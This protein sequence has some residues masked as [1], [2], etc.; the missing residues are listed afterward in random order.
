MTINS[1]L[2]DLR[3]GVW[4]HYFQPE[5]TLLTFLQEN[6]PCQVGEIDFK[7]RDYLED[8]DILLI[9]QNGLND[10]VEN[11]CEYMHNFVAAGKICYLQH[12][13]FERWSTAFLPS[14]LGCPYLVNRYLTTISAQHRSY[15]LPWFENPAHPIFSYPNQLDNSELVYWEIPGNSFAIQRRPGPPE[16]LRTAALSCV[17]NC[18]EWEILGSY[19]DAAVPEAALIL[20]K[21]YGQGLFFWNQILFP[22]TR[23]PDHHPICQF[24]QR[25]LTNTLEYL[26]KKIQGKAQKIELA[27]APKK[28][29]K[30]FP[31]KKIYRLISHLHSL[32]WYGADASLGSI[33]AAMKHFN[34]EIGLLSVKDICSCAG[35][36]SIEDFCDH[37]VLLIP[38]QEFHPFNWNPE[39]KAFNHNAY[40][41]LAIGTTEFST[42]FTRSLYDKKEI[43]EY[44]ETALQFIREH[45]GV[46]CA[47][48]PYSDYWRKYP[49]DAVDVN[50][51]YDD[52][53]QAFQKKEK[54]QRR[55]TR[56]LQGTAIEK[57]L[58]EGGRI[59]LMTSVDM[60]GV[61]RL[62]ENPVFQ[63][64]YLDGAPT[65]ENLVRAI[66]SGRVMPAE[67]IQAADIR[68]GE[69]L[70]GD[71][72]P[73][74]QAQQ[75]S[76]TVSILAQE[77]LQELRLYSHDQLIYQEDLRD[78][79]CLERNLPLRD[80][81]L[82]TF[83][84]LEVTG[85]K[86]ILFSNPFYLSAPLT[87][88]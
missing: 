15:L 40:H 26:A 61:Q 63:F 73:L 2:A 11:N 80:Y 30:R 87:D 14:A 35:K 37:R 44:L 74:E 25:Y 23:L 66:R 47:T 72:L 57:H 33:N 84:R 5:Y 83:L 48:H 41:I 31:Q 24:W 76:L 88:G 19:R 21:A 38:G 69:C 13:D 45:G 9:E 29:H 67:Y 85:E 46:S 22:E 42:A 58:L 78:I 17:V 86:A 75:E 51:Q 70:P 8:L 36:G 68:L 12:Q 43:E 4:R 28:S 39:D 7:T 50:L 1:S 34:F 10:Y 6:F 27:A 64:I 56:T 18:P 60:W 79:L 71:C 32:D 53:A 82:K 62:Q 20:E 77:P 52:V 54:L 3:I 59:T 65:R 16:I 81:P 55:P 49:Y